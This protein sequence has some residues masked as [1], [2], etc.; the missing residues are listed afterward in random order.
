MLE[1]IIE[2]KWGI[3]SKKK[4]NHSF[5][6]VMSFVV[7][8]LYHKISKI[9]HSKL[10]IKTKTKNKE[11]EKRRGN[12]SEHNQTDGFPIPGSHKIRT[13]PCSLCLLWRVHFHCGQVLDWQQL[14]WNF[15]V[16]K[17]SKKPRKG[18]NGISGPGYGKKWTYTIW[19]ISDGLW[20]PKWK[21]S[22][23]GMRYI[24]QQH[25]DILPRH[26]HLEF[27]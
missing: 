5:W 26:S 24:C 4:R 18:G 22:L 12:L 16:E 10:V 14:E 6:D 27:F 8:L 21:I 2:G 7:L 17:E 1:E 20:K 11:K 25:E 19:L 23:L 15:E 3:A 13:F 9:V